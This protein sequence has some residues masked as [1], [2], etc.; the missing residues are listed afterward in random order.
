MGQK[1]CEGRL[2]CSTRSRQEITNLGIDSHNIAQLTNKV[3]SIVNE[4][5]NAILAATDMVNLRLKDKIKSVDNQIIQKQRMVRQKR[6]DWEKY[7]LDELEEE[8]DSLAERK[9]S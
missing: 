6:L 1:Y 2:L 9:K 8:I 3:I 5:G 7:Q 4:R